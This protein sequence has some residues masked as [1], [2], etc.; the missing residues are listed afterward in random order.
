MAN[1]LDTAE[2]WLQRVRVC[3]THISHAY[4]CSAMIPPPT[5]HI[6]ANLMQ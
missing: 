6:Q 5:L 1:A 4:G 2:T 3:L